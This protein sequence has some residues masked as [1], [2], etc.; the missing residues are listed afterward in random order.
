MQKE[1][2]SEKTEIHLPAGKDFGSQPK[3]IDATYPFILINL[4]ACKSTLLR[5]DLENTKFILKSLKRVVSERIP[6]VRKYTHTLKSQDNLAEFIHDNILQNLATISIGLQL[7]EKFLVLDHLKA[8]KKLTQLGKLARQGYHDINRFYTK[9][10]R[11]QKLIR[12]GLIPILHT[13][14]ETFQDISGIR[15]DLKVFGTDGYF[16][17]K[18]KIALLQIIKEGIINAIKHSQASKIDLRLDFMDSRI[19]LMIVDNGKGFS[20]ETELAK[21]KISGHLGLMEM[22][23]RAKSLE[24]ELIIKSSPGL[25]TKI[26]LNAP[27]NSSIN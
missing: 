19:I 17:A 23:K 27:K 13:C 2:V 1:L 22:K 5:K 24:G 4:K 16:P 6:E 7:C 18:T 21:A 8:L 9:K 26:L 20:L 12:G 3:L 11:K 15:I 25:G 10:S 14:A